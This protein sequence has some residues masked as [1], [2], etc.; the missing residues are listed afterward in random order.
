VPVVKFAAAARGTKKKKEVVRAVFPNL[1]KKKV[2]AVE[3]DSEVDEDE[4][5]EGED[6]EG[7]EDGDDEGG[8]QR[9]SKRVRRE[10]G[11]GEE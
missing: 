3:A 7:E 11:E 6:D 4:G 1:K 2:A 5:G 10:E 8:Q 9:E